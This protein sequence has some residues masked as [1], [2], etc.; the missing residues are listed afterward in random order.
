MRSARAAVA[1]LGLV[2]ALATGAREAAPLDV[3]PAL[4]ARVVQIAQEMR[5]LVCQNETLADSQADLAV[6]LRR[7]IREHLQRGD[8][9]EQVGDYLVARYGEFVRYRPRFGPTTALL[10][11]GPF[12]LLAIAIGVLLAQLRRRRTQAPAEALSEADIERLA[13]LRAGAGAAR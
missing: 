2:L 11:A 9:P 13:A 6:D 4:E 3:D 1:L 5:C 7:Q 12:V 8:S 10:W